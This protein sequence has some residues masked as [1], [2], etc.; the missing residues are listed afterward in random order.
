MDCFLPLDP[1][2]IGILFWFD[3]APHVHC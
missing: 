3:Q 1:W 2:D